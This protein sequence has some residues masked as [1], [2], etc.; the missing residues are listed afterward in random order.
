VVKS[1]GKNA[2]LQRRLH[3]AIESGGRA[4]L[5]RAIPGFGASNAETAK[6]LAMLNTVEEMLKNQG[7][8]LGTTGIERSI[9]NRLLLGLPLGYVAGPAGLAGGAALVAG[10]RL[11]TN[12]RVQAGVARGLWGAANKQLPAN[13][14]RGVDAMVSDK[15]PA[16]QP[17]KKQVDSL[18][19]RYRSGQ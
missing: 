19:E 17:N 10:E 15:T 5:E 7:N 11:A 2:P 3:G 13:A 1:G 6:R 9:V 18:Y 16:K 8:K 4:T 12:P 14:A